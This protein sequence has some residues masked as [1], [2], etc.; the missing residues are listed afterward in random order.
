M[1]FRDAMKVSRRWLYFTGQRKCP[2]PA[3]P[4]NHTE[5]EIEATE[6]WEYDDSVASYLLSQRLPDTTVMRLSSCPTTKE[7]WDMVTREFQA[8][9][10]YA[11]A[12]LHQS[13]LEMR[14]AKGGDVREF[15]ASLC[16][17][18]EELAAAGVLVT[19]KEYER[20]I[21]RG[22][23][24]ELATFASHILSSALIVHSAK[25]IDID[26]LINQ[27]NEEAERLKSRRTRG[28]HGQGG[29]KEA[30]DEALAAT[31]S[32][33][34]K[35]KQR[36]K[37]NCH[38]CGKSGHW[39]REC[40]SPKKDKEETVA[41]PAAKTPGTSYKPE[42]KPVGSAN[43]VTSYDFE[44]DGFWMAEDE[45]VDLELTVSIEPDPLLGSPDDFEDAPHQEGE[46]CN[47]LLGR[48]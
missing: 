42:N 8:K 23:P 11:Q 10:A 41:T 43:A 14:C 45:A 25:A 39:A 3:D 38:N 29:K 7:R 1:R 5:A 37:G 35:K 34:G 26:A 46:E 16:Y 2:Q 40:R 32:E 20:T 15:L 28:Q 47:R 22:I 31:G 19:E 13:F 30:T 4:D 6:Q 24:N 17:K 18:K 48:G 33:G 44:G 36:R 9:S 12:D 27:I 21:L